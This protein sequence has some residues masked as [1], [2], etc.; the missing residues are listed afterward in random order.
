MKEVKVEFETSL[1]HIDKMYGVVKPSVLNRFREMYRYL[2]NMFPE[3]S[4]S[5]NK[6]ATQ[7]MLNHPLDKDYVMINLDKGYMINSVSYYSNEQTNED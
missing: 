5:I 1:Q 7:V 2:S 6:E 4:F 3:Y